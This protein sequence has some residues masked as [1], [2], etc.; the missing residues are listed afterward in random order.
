VTARLPASGMAALEAANAALYTAVE[1]GDFDAMSTLWVEGEIGGSAVC[2]HPGWPAVVGRGPILRAWAL[3]MANTTYIQFF[4]TDV[5]SWIVDD[6]GVVSCQEN[7]L[8]GMESGGDG[9]GAFSSGRVVATNLF[10]WGP[11]GWK[12]WMH[13][14][15]PVLATDDAEGTYGTDDAGSGGDAS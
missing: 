14:A 11:Q 10:R 4:L 12:A 15:S 8:T 2:V 1:T 6:V 9:S 3:I 7:I 13:H 5:Q